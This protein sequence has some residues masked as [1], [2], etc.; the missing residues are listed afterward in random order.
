MNAIRKHSTCT[1]GTTYKDQILQTLL[2][3][4]ERENHLKK[5]PLLSYT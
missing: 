2:V 4:N 5:N 1:V 3:A